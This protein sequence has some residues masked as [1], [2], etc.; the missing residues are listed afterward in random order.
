MPKIVE[1]D[2]AKIASFIR[3]FP[4]EF[5]ST[6]KRELYCNLCSKIVDHSKR[7]PVD[8]HRLSDKHQRLLNLQQP[9]TSQQFIKI[10][11]IDFTKKVTEAFLSAD[12]PLYKLRN[13]KLRELFTC[14][15]HPLP[16]EQSCRN[17]IPELFSTE[18]ER[19]KNIVQGKHIFMIVDESEVA[20]NKF[21]NVLVG[22][23]EEP[24]KTI[25]VDCLPLQA[26]VNA[27]K[28]IHVIGDTM[29]T[30]GCLREDLYLLL[31]DAAS[32][33]I[34]AAKTLH[35]LYPNLF[36]VTCMAH[37][38]HNCAMKVKAHYNNVDLLIA[39]IKAATV[40]NRTRQTS[41]DTIGRP[42]APIVTRWATWINAAS[43][44]E[45]N[46]PVV[47]QIVQS[48]VGEGKILTNAKEIIEDCS[49]IQNLTNI[50]KHYLQ[51]ADLVKT[52]ES[53]SCTVMDVVT[54]LKT[55]Y[56]RQDPCKIGTYLKKRI[57]RNEILAPAEIAPATYALLQKCQAS[58]AAV[59]RVG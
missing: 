15:G 4:K 9:S 44:Y 25:L 29:T 54:A 33:M 32:Y 24:K 46:L 17:K 52:F 41:F 47:K 37:L 43:Y 53:P 50:E 35:I 7:F 57:D 34:S 23:I 14:T 19:I 12:I 8:R 16:S 18:M 21:L 22:V 42:P 1:S 31:T 59:E 51:L 10:P 36:H 28:I 45:K 55:V 38:M 20:G 39:N 5:T 27:Q 40:K 48:W 13:P 58:S 6:P 26:S 49:L 11:Q 3:E 30:L 2:T 56:F